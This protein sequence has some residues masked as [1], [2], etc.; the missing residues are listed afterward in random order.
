VTYRLPVMSLI[1]EAII[2]QERPTPRAIAGMVIVL[3]G[4][5]LARHGA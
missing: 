5:A 4:V 3:L 1:L 2:P